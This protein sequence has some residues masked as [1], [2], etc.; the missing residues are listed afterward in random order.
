M[1]DAS[2]ALLDRLTRL[3]PKVIDLSLDRLRVLLADLGNPERSIAPVIHIAGTNG[4]GSTQAMIRAGLEAAGL[5]VNAYT[6]PHLARFNERIRLPDGDISDADLAAALAEVERVNA[7]RPITFFEVTTAAAFL[8]FSRVQ[9]DFTLLEVGLGGRL[10]ATNVIDA[11]R[12]TVITP[13]S[14]DHTQ[15][16]GDTLAKIAAEKAGILKR[17]VPC[18][19]ARQRD[20]AMQVIEL[21][22]ARLGARLSA[23][24]QHWTAAREGE[25]LV[26]QDERGLVDVPLPVDRKSVV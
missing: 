21:A 7:D 12:L 25:A 19:V 13:V 8:A 15:Y 23:E 16:L 26:F 22:A 14:I 9:A 1:A 10:D 11:P 5:R 18:V 20:D 6:S 24:G 3:H 2:D 17:G 4:K